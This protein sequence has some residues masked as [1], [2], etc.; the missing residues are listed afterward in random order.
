[1]VR[2]QEA[3]R[4]GLAAVDRR[5]P[6]A[7]LFRS[8][9]VAQGLRDVVVVDFGIVFGDDAVEGRLRL[10]VLAVGILVSGHR[11]VGHAEREVG[12]GVEGAPGVPFAQS[13]NIRGVEFVEPFAVEVAQ[14]FGAR[15]P[16]DV[17]EHALRSRTQGGRR[18]G[19][20]LVP[21]L[22]ENLLGKGFGRAA[23]GH[24][25]EEFRNLI[26]RRTAVG[27]LPEL[28]IVQGA[29]GRFAAGEDRFG[30]LF[31]GVSDRKCAER[32]ERDLA[33]EIGVCDAGVLGFE[34]RHDAAVFGFV[35]RPGVERLLIGAFR[36][37]GAAA[38]DAQHLAL[39][40]LPGVGDRGVTGGVEDAQRGIGLLRLG[41]DVETARADGDLRRVG[42]LGDVGHG[43]REDILLG[44]C[45][46]SRRS[47]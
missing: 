42:T 38:F 47:S 11:A 27:V 25:V 7:V 40:L 26:L 13:F 31:G 37:H 24:A 8:V 21:D 32:F 35:L 28:Q 22:R 36:G 10:V 23:A 30:A 1:M 41:D 14:R 20:A 45:P 3:H 12:I 6:A 29:F 44:C 39:P 17:V 46:G 18:R 33:G 43:V 15:E 19:V 2:G 5:R 4:H 9:E 34:L 16:C